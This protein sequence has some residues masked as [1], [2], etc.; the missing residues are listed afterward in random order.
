MQSDLAI[1]AAVICASAFASTVVA[2]RVLIPWLRRR[3][4]IDIPNARSSHRVPTPRGGGVGIVLGIAIA[5][6]VGAR[7]GLKIPGTHL[8]VAALVVAACG[9]WDDL[10]GGLPIGLR[11]AIQTA[12]AAQ[13][14]YSTGGLTRL[15]LPPPFN[16]PLGFLSIPLAAIWIVGT[17]NL[18]NF[19][20]GIDGYAGVQGAVGGLVIALFHFGEVTTAIGLAIM[21]ACLGFLFYNWHPAKVFM[22]DVGAVTL[23]FLLASLPFEMPKSDSSSAVFL[24]AMSLWFFLS[25][26]VFTVLTRLFRGDRIWTPHKTHLYQQLV[27][28][29]VRHDR[30]VRRLGGPML[31]LG[32]LA[33]ISTIPGFSSLQ[34]LVL[35]AAV[36]SFIAY[37]AVVRAH[38]AKSHRPPLATMSK[39]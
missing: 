15:A 18:F 19:L 4:V 14:A 37:V 6:V 11:L 21:G 17:L 34:W 2:T 31:V 3:G 7:L 13:V 25:D 8:W 35:C 28:Q 9:L 16:I 30:V 12:A 26:G 22:G 24:V 10:A 36:L 38:K 27:A 32:G 29:G 23:G 1:Q 39:A 20:D 5:T 33:L